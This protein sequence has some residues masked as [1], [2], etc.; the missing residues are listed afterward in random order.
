M[1]VVGIL[2]SGS[3]ETL[4]EQFVAFH[5]GL[6]EAGYVDGQN[7]TTQYRW[8]YDDY[9]RGDRRKLEALAAEL[10]K[11][12]VAVLVAAGGPVSAL[13]AK[14]AA[15]RTPI[16]FTTVTDPV[17]SGLIKSSRQAGR[18][19]DRDRRTYLRAR[20]GTTGTAART[21]SEG[22]RDR[23]HCQPEP[24]GRAG[25]AERRPEGQGG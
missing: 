22:R 15:R 24:S 21:L 13:A 19:T 5:R 4:G 25:S 20:P 3:P 10:V 16:V 7:V 1:K 14:A 11:L 23:R 8:C 17:K 12:P 6:E 9:K 18:T 2:N